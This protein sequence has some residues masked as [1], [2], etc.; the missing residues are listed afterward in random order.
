[1]SGLFPRPLSGTALLAGTLLVL[2]GLVA[3]APARAGLAQALG[4][5]VAIFWVWMLWLGILL[6]R[7]VPATV[8]EPMAQRASR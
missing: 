2:H 6:W 3:T 8:T 5:A 7:R 4:V 1:M